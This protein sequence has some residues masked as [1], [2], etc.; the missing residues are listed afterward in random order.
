MS[1]DHEQEHEHEHGVSLQDLHA[2]SGRDAVP[3]LSLSQA[4]PTG[5]GR[6]SRSE[7]AVPADILARAQTAIRRA[8]R[9]ASEPGVIEERPDE[10]PDATTAEPELPIDSS[11]DDP[12]DASADT[13]DS[14]AVDPPDGPSDERVEVPPPPAA[15]TRRP[16]P[17]EAPPG[18]A[19]DPAVPIDPP[20]RWPGYN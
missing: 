5:V 6:C 16:A 2:T 11:P 9:P 1:V 10:S 15:A 8:N 14:A 17:W 7:P 13:V 4:Q 19:D 3:N 12:A 18:H 20:T